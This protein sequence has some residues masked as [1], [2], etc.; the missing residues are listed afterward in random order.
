MPR[1][2]TVVLHWTTLAQ[3]RG[4][5]LGWWFVSKKICCLFEQMLQ[6]GFYVGTSRCG[7]VPYEGRNQRKQ[8]AHFHGLQLMTTERVW[9]PHPTASQGPGMLED[10]IFYDHQ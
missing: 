3:L 1:C 2:L 7:F 5:D 8:E 6:E 9:Q 10:P 4:Q